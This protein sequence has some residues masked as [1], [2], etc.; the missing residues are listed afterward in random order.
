MK[1]DCAQSSFFMTFDTSARLKMSSL[2]AATNSAPFSILHDV[3][4]TKKYSQWGGHFAFVWSHHC[5]QLLTMP[6]SHSMVTPVLFPCVDDASQWSDGM[7]FDIIIHFG[8]AASKRENAF[9]LWSLLWC[10]SFHSSKNGRQHATT[11]SSSLESHI[12]PSEVDSHRRTVIQVDAIHASSICSTASP[13]SCNSSRSHLCGSTRRESI[14]SC[15][16]VD[17]GVPK[18]INRDGSRFWVYVS[19]TKRFGRGRAVDSVGDKRHCASAGIRPTYPTSLSTHVSR[20]W[21]CRFVWVAT[22]RE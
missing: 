21:I 6:W 12:E 4:S 22:Y 16:G 2:S 20:W 1:I 14:G 10:A 9:D 11:R 17:L 18:F 5:L 8:W 3:A 7:T 19:K 15:L 13:Q